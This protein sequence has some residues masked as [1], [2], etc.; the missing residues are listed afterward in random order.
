MNWN[1]IQNPVD[2]SLCLAG[3]DIRKSEQFSRKQDSGSIFRMLHELSILAH[4]LISE[5]GGKI[6]KLMGDSGLIIFPEKST[7]AA[8][9]VLME[10]RAKGEKLLSRYAAL[11]I[12]IYCHVGEVTLGPLGPEGRLDA[13]G[14]AVNTLFKLE[15]DYPRQD[16]ILSPQVFRKLKPETRALFHKHAPQ[17]VYLG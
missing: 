10:F 14:R 1:E 5:Q 7:D 6:L 11:Q 16:I 2:V 13:I 17:I 9:R 12:S 8:V 15:H 4:Q 3:Y